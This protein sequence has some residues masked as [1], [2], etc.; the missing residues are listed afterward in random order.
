[1]LH[2]AGEVGGGSLVG[3]EDEEP[4]VFE[5]EGGEGGVAVGGI[6]VEGAL[7]NVCARGFGDLDGV[8]GGEGVEDVDVVGPGDGGETVGEILLLVAGED[9][10]GDHLVGH[11]KRCLLDV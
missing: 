2:L 7:V 4:G 1:M 9:E 5:G 3:V 11:L 8:V 6:V 10:D